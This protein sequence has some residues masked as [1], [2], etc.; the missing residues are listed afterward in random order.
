MKPMV[1]ASLIAIPLL[2]AILAGCSDGPP[3]GE[4]AAAS[5][6]VSVD[7]A[8][9]VQVRARVDPLNDQRPGPALPPDVACAGNQLPPQLPADQFRCV[10]PRTDV[11]ITFRSLASGTQS[12][13][14]YGLVPGGQEELLGP[15]APTSQPADQNGH[16]THTLNLTF[17][18]DMSAAYTQLQV[19]LGDVVVAQAPWQPGSQAYFE[20][21]STLS[22]VTATG[23][24]R[25][26]E[27][28]LDVQGLP[29]TGTFHGYLYRADETGALQQV[30][31]FPNL[32]NGEQTL[33]A[34]QDISDYA[35]FHIH[36]ADSRINL[37][38]ATIG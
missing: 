16:L 12:Y 5:S 29:P 20:L 19:R 36:L 1:K 7:G 8:A 6:P 28:T 35:E 2:A 30:Q 25:G 32:T 9:A 23:S 27:L 18:A 38:K 33:T 34:P 11:N 24:Y 10:D 13:T 4:L 3:T 17:P 37:F 14:A 15:L 22:Q 31:Q 21:N 26:R